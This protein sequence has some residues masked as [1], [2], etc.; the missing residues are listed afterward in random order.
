MDFAWWGDEKLCR[1]CFV[2]H[3]DQKSPEPESTILSPRTSVG[4]VSSRSFAAANTL[5]DILSVVAWIIIGLSSF[6]FLILVSEARGSEQTLL[7]VAAAFVSVASGLVFLALIQIGRA[8]VYSAETN[9]EL[10]V[11]ARKAEARASKAGI[12]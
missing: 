3:R 9:G 10:L 1:K 4:T 11:L 2:G 7:I 5:F 6:G 12:E 8:T